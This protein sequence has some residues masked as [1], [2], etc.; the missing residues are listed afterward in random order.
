MYNHVSTYCIY[1]G[2][3]FAYV[4]TCK[5]RL[6]KFTRLLFNMAVQL[7]CSLNW[8]TLMW[9]HNTKIICNNVVIAI[10]I[11]LLFTSLLRGLGGG[12]GVNCMLGPQISAL[13]RGM[14]PPWIRPWL[15]VNYDGGHRLILGIVVLIG[16]NIPYLCSVKEAPWHD[17]D[18]KSCTLIFC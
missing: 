2:G 17:S 11:N 13:G 15:H 1:I 16:T 3:L 7:C 18:P 6:T 8:Q 12:G 14:G 9:M 10:Y 5:S 4:T